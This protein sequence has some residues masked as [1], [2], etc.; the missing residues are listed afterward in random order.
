MVHQR[1]TIN[2][3]DLRRY[4]KDKFL[5]G[6]GKE[7]QLNRDDML[8]RRSDLIVQGVYF[9]RS[10]YGKRFVP[11]FFIQVLAIPLDHF[12][13]QLGSRLR[14]KRGAELWL[15]WAL[16][17][18]AMVQTILEAYKKQADPPL[19]Q[20][21]TLE[22]AIRYLETAHKSDHFYDR[23]SLGILYGLQGRLKEAC[24]QLDLAKQNLHI[25]VKGWEKKG[26]VPPDWMA[27]DIESISD[28]LS[29][30]EITDEFRAYCEKQAKQT[31]IALKLPT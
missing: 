14:D 23:W 16:E 28:F 22:R 25:G 26:K 20:P 29:R 11:N 15:D 21:L 9:D 24:Q 7:W 8:L 5:P 19:D 1:L 3:R 17:D 10:S 6:L 18:E 31:A 12:A 2:K 4:L 30:V 13:M 27:K